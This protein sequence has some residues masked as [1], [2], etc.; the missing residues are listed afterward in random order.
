MADEEKKALAD[1]VNELTGDFRDKC[2]MA[3]ISEESAVE[4]GE[5]MYYMG[6]R[7][8]YEMMELAVRERILLNDHIAVRR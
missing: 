1:A 6:V 5:R 8:A 7:H 3:R 2:R 4:Y